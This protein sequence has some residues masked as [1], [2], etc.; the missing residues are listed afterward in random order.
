MFIHQLNVVEVLPVDVDRHFCLLL[1]RAFREGIQKWE[2]YFSKIVHE[3]STC[4]LN[5]LQLPCATT[6]SE[7]EVDMSH[8]AISL[9]FIPQNP[10]ILQYCVTPSGPQ[11]A[12]GTCS[13]FWPLS[14]RGILYTVLCSL[15]QI[16]R[17]MEEPKLYIF[18]CFGTQ[19]TG[20]RKVVPFI[21]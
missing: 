5:T 16:H 9:Y 20:C 18:S 3:V 10:G 7:V 2:Y 15:L 19:I 4:W 12:K 13:M 17:L 8:A 1:Q 6:R 21:N 11:S 14:Q